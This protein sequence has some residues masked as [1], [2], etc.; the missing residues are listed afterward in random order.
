MVTVV[1]SVSRQGETR[2]EVQLPLH[3][4]RLD[5]LFK[6][7]PTQSPVPVVSDVTPI[8]Y[9]TKEVAQI[10]VWYLE[11]ANQGDVSV[12]I[13]PVVLSRSHT[14]SHFQLGSQNIEFCNPLQTHRKGKKHIYLGISLQVVV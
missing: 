13:W 5:K 2:C 3:H 7:G 9:L 12:R 1:I 11:I 10:V 6:V 4:L 8:H 14:S